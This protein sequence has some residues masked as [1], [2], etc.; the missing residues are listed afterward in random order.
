MRRIGASTPTKQSLVTLL[1]FSIA[2]RAPVRARA[3]VLEGEILNARPMKGGVLNVCRFSA[4][5]GAVTGEGTFHYLPA[6]AAA[7]LLEAH[8]AVGLAM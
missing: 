7:V 4:Q 3:V 8:G 5:G 2:C 1:R 6:E